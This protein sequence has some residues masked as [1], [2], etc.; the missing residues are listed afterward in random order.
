LLAD[1]LTLSSGR[2][3]RERLGSKKRRDPRIV[4]KMDFRRKLEIVQTL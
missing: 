3:M 1:S 2:E 4:N